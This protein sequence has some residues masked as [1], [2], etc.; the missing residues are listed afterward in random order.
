MVRI[1][2]HLKDRDR[3]TVVFNTVYLHTVM[4]PANA[5]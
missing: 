3:I 1:V 2:R 4:S 5:A